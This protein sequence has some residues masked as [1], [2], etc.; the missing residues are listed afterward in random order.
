MD[1]TYD[2]AKSHFEEHQIDEALRILDKCIEENSADIP[3]LLLRA[4]IF[5]KSQK[6]GQAMND[7]LAVLELEPDIQEAKTG[8][9]LAQNILA[10][11]NPDMFNP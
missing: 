9:A 7:Y 2:Q 8:L 3:S 10:Y 11:F 1:Q 5:S 4:R 6:W